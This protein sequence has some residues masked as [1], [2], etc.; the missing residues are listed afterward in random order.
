M[1]EYITEFLRRT[2][3]LI[4]PG[5]ARTKRMEKFQ[6]LEESG[7]LAKM[8]ASEVHELFGI[9]RVSSNF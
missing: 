9:K 2:Y 1:R 5:Y 8:C 6:E 4:A 7:K 3:E